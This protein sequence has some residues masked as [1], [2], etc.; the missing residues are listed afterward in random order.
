M[1]TEQFVINV[2]CTELLSTLS[3]LNRVLFDNYLARIILPLSN[4]SLAGFCGHS[5]FSQASQEL[6][7]DHV[8]ILNFQR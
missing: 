1:N 6:K 8:E 4:I 5:L 7:A 2:G 3:N